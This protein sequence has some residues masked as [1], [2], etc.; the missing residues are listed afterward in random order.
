MADHVLRDRRLTN[1]DPELQQLAVDPKR[2]PQPIRSR[3]R[4]NQCADVG[5]HGRSTE[6]AAA[7]P[8]PQQPEAAAVPADNRV[9]PDDH[10][11]RS[12]FMPNPRQTN[13]E[14]AVDAREANP[15]RPR[16]IKHAQ[17]VPQREYFELQRR[18]R[19]DRRSNR[20]QQRDEDGHHRARGYPAMGTI[21][22]ASNKNRIVSS[23]SRPGRIES[24]SRRLCS[25]WLPS[26]RP[27]STRCPKHWLGR[28]ACQRPNGAGRPSRA[29]PDGPGIAIGPP[30]TRADL[31]ALTGTSIYFASRILASWEG[32]R[33]LS[34][35]RGHIRADQR[36]EASNTKAGAGIA[37]AVP[38]CRDGWLADEM[39]VKDDA[40]RDARATESLP[41][42]AD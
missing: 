8:G 1:V 41:R 17:L 31:A 18:T 20:Q 28:A 3:H 14:H 33:I 26:C 5:W 35:R 34:S 15:P 11:R 40:A 32:Q 16:S 13:P 4:A 22:N 30:V 19:T 2:A 10:E 29:L 37:H 27:K 36:F 7:L 42:R 38:A 39:N 9:G 21:I 6:P 24:H 12:P 23:H 25:R